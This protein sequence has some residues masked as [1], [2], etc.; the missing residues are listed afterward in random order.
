[1]SKTALAQPGITGCSHLGKCWSLI[2]ELKWMY[3]AKKSL[4]LDILILL[5]TP[6]IILEKTPS[7]S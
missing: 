4:F 6:W 7:D 1:M 3:Y 2:K 5:K